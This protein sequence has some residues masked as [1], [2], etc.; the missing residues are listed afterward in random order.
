[1]DELNQVINAFGSY[2]TQYIVGLESILNTFWTLPLFAGIT[3][4]P[5][6]LFFIILG[7]LF[8]I[9]LSFVRGDD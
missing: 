9:L 8:S 5:L 7:V 2:A 1:M 4:G 6:L 3:L